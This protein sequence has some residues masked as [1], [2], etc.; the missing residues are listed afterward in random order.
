MMMNIGLVKIFGIDV[1]THYA[2]ILPHDITLRT[3]INYTY[4]QARDFSDTKKRS[5]KG[6]IAYIPWHNASATLGVSYK[7]WSLN[8][9]FIYVGER[10]ANS[11]NIRENYQLPW[12]TSDLS[13]AKDFKF[14]NSLRLNVSAEINNL[15]N[16]QFEVV[17]N[18][19]MPGV[20]FKIICKVTF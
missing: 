16:Q 17:E 15:L 11:E 12:Y 4:Q 1:K 18:Y 5:Y 2:I 8:Y 13:L 9:C 7:T 6:Q 20:N 19:P 10:Y 3:N 14:K